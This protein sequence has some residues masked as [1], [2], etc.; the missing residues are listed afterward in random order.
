MEDKSGIY[1]LG[2][3]AYQ[4]LVLGLFIP[5]MAC[6]DEISFETIDDV[7]TTLTQENLDG[8]DNLLQIQPSVEQ[9][10]RF[11]IQVKKTNVNTK[12]AASIIKNW[13]L[14]EIANKD[15]DSYC[16]YTDREATPLKI[17]ER[18][19]TS[20]IV[21]DIKTASGK[22]S[23]INMR[24][25]SYGY[26]KQ[27]LETICSRVINKSGVKIFSDFEDEIKKAYEYF[28]IS[29]SVTKYVYVNRIRD[30][31][32]AIA[33]EILECVIYGKAYTLKYEHAAKLQSKVLE[34]IRDEHIEP[35]Y[36]NFKKL[37]KINLSDLEIAN[38]REYKQLLECGLENKAIFRNLMWGEYYANCKFGYYEAGMRTLV[39]DI[40]E[41]AYENFCET[42]ERLQWLNKDTPRNRLDGTKEMPNENAKNTQ[43]KYGACIG[44]TKD[45]VDSKLQISWKD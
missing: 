9:K 22:P 44:L 14:V 26:S 8:V 7:A 29:A 39:D 16:L 27:E 2:G 23:S 24:L 11:S 20:D 30:F 1:S 18:V 41:T 15:I 43:I 12:K 45:N 31:L 13:M 34:S 10:K 25:K 35:S 6:G 40:E 21:N 38:S 42:K 17:F 28:F 33:S 37:N 32:S 5:Q 19:S 3:F 36:A 4:I